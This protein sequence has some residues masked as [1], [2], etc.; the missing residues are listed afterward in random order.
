M[1]RALRL[2]YAPSKHIIRIA[3]LQSLTHHITH[4]FPATSSIPLAKNFWQ[5]LLQVLHQC[6]IYCYLF[7][8]PARVFNLNT[9]YCSFTVLSQKTSFLSLCVSVIKI[10]PKLC[11]IAQARRS[12]SAS[13]YGH[14]SLSKYHS[15]A[16]W[17]LG[18]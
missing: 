7:Q 10:W 14:P 13:P 12:Q 18:Q 16:E 15:A 3:L 5:E 9:L 17:D 1:M 2:E 8:C 4:L 6:A 11:S